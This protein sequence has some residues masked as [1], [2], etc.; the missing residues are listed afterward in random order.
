MPRRRAASTTR[1]SRTR[2]ASRSRSKTPRASWCGSTAL[3]FHHPRRQLLTVDPHYGHIEVHPARQLEYNLRWPGHYYDPE[4]ALHYNRY[5]YYDPG[6]GRYLQ[7]DPLGYEG[8]PTNLYGYPANPLTD[9][10]VLGLAHTARGT[11]SSRRRSGDSD[12]TEGTTRPPRR[13]GDADAPRRGGR[14]LGEDGLTDRQRQYFRERIDS[15]PDGSREANQARY[16]RHVCARGNAGEE[17]MAPRDWQAS[18]DRLRANSERG[19][20]DESAA[21][22]AMGLENNN[23]GPNPRT[24]PASDGHTR[25]DGVGGR[26]V[27]D[28]KSV[29]DTPDPAGGPRVIYNTDQLASQR[30]GAATRD[31]LDHTVVMTNGNR[32]NCR[33]SAPLAERSA[34]FH[35]DNS[36]G[37]W[38]RWDRAEGRWVPSSAS[39]ARSSVG[40]T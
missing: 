24:Y 16:D 14:P 9:V 2:W 27:V 21:L 40:G 3:L 31:G 37:R 5:R 12:A 30:G 36:T 10:D 35:R 17:P 39:E 13:G 4:T 26:S 32:D 11:R 38:S 19:R 6:L 20:A 28:V 1:C 18:H 29:P 34:V 22:R 23:E 25:P 15:H 8:S 7:T 33:P